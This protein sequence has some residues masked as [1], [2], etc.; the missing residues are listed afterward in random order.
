[1]MGLK[2]RSWLE[3]NRLAARL[4]D[5]TGGVHRAAGWPSPAAN[6]NLVPNVL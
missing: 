2:A 1:V 6:S 4:V 5:L 3:A